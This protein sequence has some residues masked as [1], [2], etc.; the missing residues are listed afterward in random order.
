MPVTSAIAIPE[1]IMH[2]G[3]NISKWTNN[4]CLKIASIVPAVPKPNMA[5]EIT[6]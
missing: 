5:I 3:K 6:I 1:A 4:L 2:T